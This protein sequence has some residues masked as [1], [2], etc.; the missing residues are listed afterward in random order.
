MLDFGLEVSKFDQQSV[1]YVHFQI[2]ILGKAMS[3][4]IFPAKGQIV[5]MLF[6][7]KEGIKL[8]TKVDIQLKT[9]KHSQTHL[10]ALNIPGWV[11]MQLKSIRQ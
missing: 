2:N 4:L 8:L 5:S 10:L 1:N 7:Y 3:P 9:K 11:H 6:F